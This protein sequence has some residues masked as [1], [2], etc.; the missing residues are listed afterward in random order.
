M[1]LWICIATQLMQHCRAQ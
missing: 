1:S